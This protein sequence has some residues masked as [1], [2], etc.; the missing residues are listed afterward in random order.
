MQQGKGG[1]IKRITEKM[2]P[3]GYNVN[4]IAP[5]DIEKE[6]HYLWRFWTKILKG[7]HIGIFDRTWYGRVL[8]ERVENLATEK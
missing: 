4:P 8:V 7:G 6:H 3:R 2:D 1:A 5:N